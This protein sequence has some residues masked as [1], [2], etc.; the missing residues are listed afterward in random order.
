MREGCDEKVRSDSAY[1]SENCAILASNE[2][3]KKISLDLPTIQQSRGLGDNSSRS[4]LLTQLKDLKNNDSFRKRQIRLLEYRLSLIDECIERV[5]IIHTQTSST[6]NLICGF[7]ERICNDWISSSKLFFDTFDT[8][9]V[10]NRFAEDGIDAEHNGPSTMCKA[11]GKCI[12]H[13]GWQLMKTHE[14]EL[15][16]DEE[17]KAYCLEKQ[18]I[19]QIHAKLSAKLLI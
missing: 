13:E 18:K 8:L 16:L 4:S 19:V 5:K 12:L 11:T 1:C 3:L 7:D 15:D 2:R 6:S 9:P 10:A 14:A 17:I